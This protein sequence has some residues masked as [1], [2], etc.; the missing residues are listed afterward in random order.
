ML[1]NPL[2]DW[3]IKRKRLVVQRVLQA[4][5]D[6][7]LENVPAIVREMSYKVQR[8][9]NPGDCPLYSTKPCHGE[10]LDLNCFLCA[11]PNYLSEKKDEQGEFTGGCSV[12]CKSGK[13]I[14]NYPSPAG[15]VW[16]CEGCS[17]FHRGV[18]VEEY[19]KTHI[20]QYSFLAESLK[21]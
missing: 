9:K 16:S 19:L 8:E 10:V 11:C 14:V 21:K 6:F 20:S 1:E 3:E 15:K 4:G 7:T 17:G 5:L 13:W 18:V 12:N 2:K